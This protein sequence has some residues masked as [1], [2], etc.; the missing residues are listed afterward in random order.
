MEPS[1]GFPRGNVLLLVV[2]LLWCWRGSTGLYFP[3]NEYLETVYVGQPAGSP[4]LQVHSMP[5]S[6]AERPHFYLCFGAARA[7]LY[8]HWF[9]LDVS[10]DKSSGAVKKLPLSAMALPR[11]TSRTHCRNQPARLSVIFVNATMPSCGQTAMQQLCFPPR[12]PPTPHI[13]ENRFAGPVQQLRRLTKLN[14]CPNYTV[15]YS[16]ESDVPVPFAVNESTMEL[17]ATA[18]LDRDKV[19][20][21]RLVLVCTVLTEKTVN[22]FDTSLEISVFDEDDNGPL[23][24]GTDSVEVTVEYDRAEGGSLVTLSVYDKDTTPKFPK[25]PSQNRYV[26]TMLTNDPWIKDTFA[27]RDTFKEDKSLFSNIRG[28]VFEYTLVLKRNLYVSE[29]RT[30]QVD[31]LVNDTTYPGPESSVVLHYNITILPVP[32]RFNNITY[33]FPVTRRASAYALVGRVCVENCLKF[34]GIDVVYQLE[35]ADKNA[36]AEAQSCHAAVDIAPS[37]RDMTGVLYVNDSEALRRAECRDLQYLLLAQEEGGQTQVTTQVLVTLDGEVARA[38]QQDQKPLSCA[39]SRQRVDCELT[40]GLGATSG[41]CQWR[42]GT[43]KGISE[44]YSTC[45][46]DLRTCPDGFCDA[47]ESKDMSI[48]PQDCTKEPVIGGHVKGLMFGIKAGYGTCYCFLKRCFCEKDDVEEAICDDMCKTVIAT[49]VLL[50]FIVSILLSSYFVHRY[51]K[52]SPK[53]PIASA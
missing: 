49:A 31:Y 2:V 40:R 33:L 46:P 14:V 12:V 43:E 7:P 41:R 22:R 19:E 51:N 24:N 48:C 20:V 9:H 18:P 11:P 5:D 27:I 38:G 23:I 50:S 4:V 25:E 13:M 42:Q 17:V 1:R 6:S 26:G 39:E 45:S 3:Q 29:N 10:T 21:Y 8:S 52:N 30:L 34:Q 28:T 37:L 44:N 32:I 16:V 15:S 53:P 47:V 36:S 35:M